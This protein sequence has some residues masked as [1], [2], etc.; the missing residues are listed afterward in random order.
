MSSSPS[1]PPPDLYTDALKCKVACEKNLTPSV[2]GFFVEKFVATM[3][4]YLQ[5]SYYKRKNGRI[6]RLL[7]CNLRL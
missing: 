5:F 7:L 3:Y 6:G 1:P 4:H 2:G